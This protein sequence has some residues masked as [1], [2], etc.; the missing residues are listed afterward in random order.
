MI[1][2]TNPVITFFRKVMKI[3]TANTPDHKD[4]EKIDRKWKKKERKKAEREKASL[5]LHQ[6]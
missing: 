2:M 5:R 4:Q 3:N 6:G 1:K